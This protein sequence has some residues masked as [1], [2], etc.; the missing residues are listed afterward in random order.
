M[1]CLLSGCP[2]TFRKVLLLKE[3]FA[4][5]SPD[6]LLL[7]CSI[8]HQNDDQASD[9]EGRWPPSLFPVPDPA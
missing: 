8:L 9:D 6:T 4:D 7:P 2:D 1:E 3:H 5:E